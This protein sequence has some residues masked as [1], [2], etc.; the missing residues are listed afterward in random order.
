[1]IKR[2]PL[3][4]M[5]AGETATVVEFLGGWRV[6][7]R[8]CALGLRPGIKIAKVS[9]AFTRGPVVVQV[10]GT[11]TAL[12]FGMSYKVIVEVER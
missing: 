8:L 12:G 1:M 5:N 4:D 11:Q 2:I 10:G 6:R 7:N 3:T 9:T